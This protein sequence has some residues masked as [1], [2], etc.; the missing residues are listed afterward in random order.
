MPKQL[1]PLPALPRL[2]RASKPA[3]IPCEC[4]CGLLTKSRFVPGHDSR[5]RGWCL[6]VERGLVELDAIPNGERQAVEKELAKRAKE[7]AA[8]AAKEKK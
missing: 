8:A 7:A 5:L 2:A 6:R 1:A 3:S 4:G